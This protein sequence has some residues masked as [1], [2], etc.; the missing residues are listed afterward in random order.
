MPNQTNVDFIANQQWL[1][2]LE[3]GLQKAVKGAFAA[4][5]ETGR[6]I[7]DVLHGVW[8]GDPLHAAITDVP[9]GAW[10]AAVVMDA[11]E[12]MTGDTRIA[13]GADAAVGI[14]LVGAV[15]SAITGLTDWQHVG[16]APRRVGLVHG[17][18]NLTSTALFTTSY[19]MRKRD[20][21]PAAKALAVSG[22]ALTLTAARLG[23]ELVYRH[24][25]GVDHAPEDSGPEEF[26]AVL[27]EAELQENSPKRV[28]ANGIPLVLVRNGNQ[29]FALAERCAHLG[30]PLSE[31]KC[32]NGVIQCPWHGS[33][34]SL[35]DGQVVHGPSVH[36]Q[37]CFDARIRQ[38][39][40]EVRRHVG[41]PRKGHERRKEVA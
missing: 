25:I 40:V 29:V 20:S 19:I 30:G 21:R 11:A 18:L 32:E 6:S 24:R 35:A 36:P 4:G 39:Q 9:I 34:F 5:G 10:T 27:A 17:L 31:G 33:Q 15:A 13:A 38:G 12:T 8:L 37:V 28:E 23:G 26:T 14:G 41:S 1:E 3:N 7:E 22:Y 16:G 2:P